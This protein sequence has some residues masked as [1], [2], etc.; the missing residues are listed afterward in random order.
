MSSETPDIKIVLDVETTGLD[1]KR[2]KIIEFGAVKL[3]NN[4]IAEE[5]ETLINPKQEI[6]YSSMEIHG[7]TSSMVENAPTI[8]EV[9]PKILE[10]IGESPI[11]AHNAI[12]DY[13]FINEACLE[14]YG[15]PFNNAKIDTYQMYK[16]VFPDDP[17][18]GLESL[19]KRFNIEVF[20]R[21][22]ALP[23]A[24]GLAY[25]YPHLR[26]FYEKKY[27]WQVSQLSNIEYLFERY[28]R[29][30]NTIQILQSEMA[31][32]KSLFKVY[33]EENQREIR[34][35]TGELLVCS[36]KHIYN[37][38]LKAL[39]NVFDFHD[40]SEK[41]FKINIGYIEKLIND[42]NTDKEFKAELMACRLDMSES[43]TVLIIKPERHS[44]FAGD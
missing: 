24:K 27:Q 41:V 13:S 4:V 6:R 1:F 9:M 29:I 44:A 7:I 43:K 5:F 17:S 10:F 15:K 16:D 20:V 14:L 12:F 18:H 39:K 38:D 8:E 21:H 40:L 35:T 28:L 22:R 32:L 3:V 2:E 23:D 33:F 11:I 36:S 42:P 31:D 25:V 37:Y 26:L 30:Q 19:L 34:S